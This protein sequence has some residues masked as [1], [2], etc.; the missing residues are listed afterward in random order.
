MGLTTRM[1]TAT[2]IITTIMAIITMNMK[3]T[4]T[5]RITTHMTTWPGGRSAML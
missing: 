3:P 5:A 2:S 4:I 1:I